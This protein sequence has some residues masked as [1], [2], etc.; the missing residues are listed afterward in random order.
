MTAHHDRQTNTQ[1]T[2]NWKVTDS[3]LVPAGRRGEGHRQLP[4]ALAVSRNGWTFTIDAKPGA[5]AELD[6]AHVDGRTVSGGYGSVQRAK[7]AARDVMHPAELMGWKKNTAEPFMI[8]VDG[9]ATVGYV[10]NAVWGPHVFRA[11]PTGHGYKFQWLNRV[12][13]DMGES[14]VP[15]D[16][17]FKDEAAVMLRNAYA[18]PAP[19]TDAMAEAD[20]L[21]DVLKRVGILATSSQVAVLRTLLPGVLASA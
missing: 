8:D 1:T 13:K 6:G 2:L 4:T 10:W 20:A 17:A 3:V 15:H 16:R 5:L 14:L 11:I 19:D 12:T 7:Q 21:A 9:V 18:S